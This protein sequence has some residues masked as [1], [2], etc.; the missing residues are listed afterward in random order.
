M[1]KGVVRVL[2]GLV[3]KIQ[4]DD[5]MPELNEMV[6]VDNKNKTPLLVS[7]L[8]HGDMALCL[9]IAGDN[10]VKKGELVTRSGHSLEIPVGDEMV[11][12]VWDAMGRPID[13]KPQLPQAVLDKMPKRSIFGPAVPGNLAEEPAG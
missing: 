3:I 12:R 9:N 7:S 6:F 8:E 11:G 1:G 10:S 4:F 13:G 5:D 2:K